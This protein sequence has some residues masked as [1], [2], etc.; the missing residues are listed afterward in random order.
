MI[1]YFRQFSY[2]SFDSVALVLWMIVSKMF[3]L[4]FPSAA[5]LCTWRLTWNQNKIPT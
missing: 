1:D 5:R 2:T 4:S 3:T